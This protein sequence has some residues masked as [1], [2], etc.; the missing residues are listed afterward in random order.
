LIQFLKDK[1]FNDKDI[2]DA[3][4]AKKNQSWDV[5]A[6]FRNRIMFP[7]QDTMGNV[8]WFSS[9]IIDP[10]DKPKYLNSWEHK[11]FEKSKERDK[12]K[13]EL[14]KSNYCDLI[15]VNENYDFT[16]VVSEIRHKI[17]NKPNRQL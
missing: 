14:C 7:I 5:Y 6:F 1:W 12:R 8:I 17:N 11:A 15:Y 10:K 13:H 4:L 9:R 16:D 3:S 2:I